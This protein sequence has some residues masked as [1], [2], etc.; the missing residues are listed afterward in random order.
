MKIIEKYYDKKNKRH[1]I[2]IFGMNITFT[3]KAKIREELKEL[4]EEVDTLHTIINMML[5]PADAKPVPELRGY[6]LKVLE[7]LNVIDQICHDNK[8]QYWLDFGTLLGAIRHKGFIPWDDDLDVCMLRD[9]YDKIYPLLLKYFENNEEWFVRKCEFFHFQI[10][11]RHKNMNLGLDIFPV[12]KY[13][14]ENLTPSVKT[15]LL[16]KMERAKNYFHKKHPKKSLSEDHIDYILAELLKTQQKFGLRLPYTPNIEKPILFYGLDYPHLWEYK[17]FEY[18]TIF[19]L[20]KI[21]FEGKSYP[22]PNQYL[23]HITSIYGDINKFPKKLGAH[24]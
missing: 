24:F 12:D 9:D 18:D 8:L 21:K 13:N 23:K 4:R 19:P 5:N 11:I 17:C 20:E 7:T 22:C 2:K 3:K 6:Q 15:E 14:Q 1:I 16:D 10:R